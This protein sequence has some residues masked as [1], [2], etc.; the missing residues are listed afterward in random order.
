[1]S[2]MAYCFCIWIKSLS[3]IA[4]R[5]GTTPLSP[6]KSP[7]GKMSESPWLTSE[8]VNR[9]KNRSMWKVS[10]GSAKASDPRWPLKGQNAMSKVRYGHVL[11]WITHNSI[12]VNDN[13]LRSWKRD[14]GDKL[15]GGCL[16][17][18]V[19]AP[20]PDLTGSKLSFQKLRKGCLLNYAKFRRDPRSASA[21]ILEKL[22][23]RGVVSTPL[24][25]AGEG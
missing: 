15:A 24:F 14:F 18:D 2:R 7:E 12:P 5:N 6:G 23:G 10:Y 1:M 3:C 11:S 17:Y 13:K 20:W 9:L 16:N 19:I 25:C 21:V 22:I 8:T 4:S